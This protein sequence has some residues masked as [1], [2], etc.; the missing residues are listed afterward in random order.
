MS[1]TIYRYEVPIDD[2]P[3]RVHLSNDPV[4]VA[5]VGHDYMEFWAEN[6]GGR[7]RERT[8]QVYRTGHIVPDSAR[9]VGTGQRTSLGLVFHLYELEA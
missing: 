5:I 9:Y 7:G 8:F 3:H 4:S 1:K 2:R 6:D